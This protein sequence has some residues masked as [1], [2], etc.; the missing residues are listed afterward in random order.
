MPPNTR[1]A[2]A[3]AEAEAAFRGAVSLAERRNAHGGALTGTLADFGKGEM[4]SQQFSVFL[5]KGPFGYSR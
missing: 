1:D 2:E 5:T 3:A 4:G